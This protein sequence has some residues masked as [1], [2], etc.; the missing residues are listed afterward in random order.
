[1]KGVSL[2]KNVLPSLY[3]KKSQS[4]DFFFQI[5]IYEEF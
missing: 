5:S 1:M 3:A 2:N 4:L